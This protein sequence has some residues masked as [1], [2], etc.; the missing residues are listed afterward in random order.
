MRTESERSPPSK[1]VSTLPSF[2]TKFWHPFNC[3]LSFHLHSFAFDHLFVRSFTRSLVRSSFRFHFNF[4]HTILYKQRNFLLFFEFRF[5]L[6]NRIFHNLKNFIF[7]SF[8]YTI[9]FLHIP[10]TSRR[11]PPLSFLHDLTF[12]FAPFLSIWFDS[13][14]SLLVSISR[15]GERYHLFG[16]A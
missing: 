1:Y 11:L 9:S 10:S 12:F 5:Q 2:S 8:S 7:C 16:H 4:V 14:A 3:L 13:F 6:Q 15:A